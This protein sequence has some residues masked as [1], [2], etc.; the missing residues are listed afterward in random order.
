MFQ[1]N[2][3]YCEY[4]R[5]CAEKVR[6]FLNT[7][8]VLGYDTGAL[9]AASFCSVSPLLRKCYCRMLSRCLAPDIAGKLASSWPTCPSLK[10][11]RNGL[12]PI[13]SGLGEG[14]TAAAEMQAAFDQA[15]EALR[16]SSSL[17][18]FVDNVLW[19]LAIGK[20]GLILNHGG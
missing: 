10:P 4:A 13:A 16:Q 6:L 2:T 20:G 19:N 11:C 15:I 18:L 17:F 8:S 7:P 3:L 12:H 1:S 5:S 9:R 14:T